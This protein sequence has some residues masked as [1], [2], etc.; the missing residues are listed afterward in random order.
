MANKHLPDTDDWVPSPPVKRNDFIRNLRQT[1]AAIQQRITL[2]AAYHADSSNYGFQSGVPIEQVVTRELTNLLPDRYTASKGEVVD[3]TGSTAGECD[4]VIHD[5]HWTP[6]VKPPPVPNSDSKLIPVESVYAII[7]VKKTVTMGELDNGMK[8]LVSANRLDRPVNPYGHITENQHIQKFDREGAVLNPLYTCL[9]GI[10]TGK[11]TN[12]E[13]MIQRFL[14]IN[15]RVALGSRDEIVTS[16]AVLD[17]GFINYGA[18]STEGSFT[19]SE[20]QTDRA[21]P[22]V[23]NLTDMPP[24]ETFFLFY[25]SLYG[26]LT[27]SILNLSDLHKRYGVSTV[28]TKIVGPILPPA[29]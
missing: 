14:D 6:F 28:N 4:I 27:R 3:A 13:A 25:Q 29:E 21:L 8:K 5:S 17:T 11:R 23:G 20:F 19:E 26:H 2:E 24:A 1:C 9:L 16:L 15:G 22:Y 7:E 12:N 18:M 10:S